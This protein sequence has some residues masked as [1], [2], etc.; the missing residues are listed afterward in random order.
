[1]KIDAHP[2]PELNN[3]RSSVI[4]TKREIVL[5]DWLAEKQEELNELY[6]KGLLARFD[7]VIEDSEP[8][9]TKDEME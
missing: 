9:N 8:G 3:L 6:Y 1:M 4:L 7:V 2:L 5:E